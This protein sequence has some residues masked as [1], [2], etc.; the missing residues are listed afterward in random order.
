MARKKGTP[1]PNAGRFKVDDPKVSINI[2]ITGEMARAGGCIT[3]RHPETNNGRIKPG[4]AKGLQRTIIELLKK[5]YGT[6]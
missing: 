5:H 4:T 3:D 2:V 1:N 6:Q